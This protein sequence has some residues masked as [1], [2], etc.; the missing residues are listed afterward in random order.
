MRRRDG[1]RA[2]DRPLSAVSRVAAVGDG[3][4]PLPVT[5]PKPSGQPRVIQKL[6]LDPILSS[7]GS[8]RYPV[9]DWGDAGRAEV[10][11]SGRRAPMLCRRLHAGSGQAGPDLQCRKSCR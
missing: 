8:G 10:L 5:G 2:A 9:T 6:P 3:Y 4:A 1:P 11:E 7:G